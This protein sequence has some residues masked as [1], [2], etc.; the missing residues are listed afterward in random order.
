MKDLQDG[1]VLGM[2]G[3]LALM[4]SEKYLGVKA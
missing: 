4:I 2:V 1:I 3:A